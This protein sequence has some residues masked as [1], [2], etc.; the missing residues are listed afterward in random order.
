MLAHQGFG[1]LQA[2]LQRR[3]RLSPPS[4]VVADAQGVY[5]TEMSLWGAV[6]GHCNL[7]YHAAGW[8][9]GGLTA[10]F[11]KLVLDVEMLQLMIEFLKPIKVDE[12]E[13][14]FEAQLQVNKTRQFQ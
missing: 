13:L 11:E 8:Q 14:G 5:E 6:L 2:R 12:A 7:V 10:S 9:E 3:C 1:V 4:R